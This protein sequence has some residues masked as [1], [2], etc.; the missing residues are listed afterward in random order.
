MYAQHCACSVVGVCTL[1]FRD[2]RAPHRAGRCAR[3]PY[4]IKLIA[5]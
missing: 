4:Y 3:A 2:A 1:T 5:L